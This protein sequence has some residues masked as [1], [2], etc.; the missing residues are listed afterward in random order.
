MPHRKVIAGLIGLPRVAV[1]ERRM[2]V[3][4]NVGVGFVL[5]DDQEHV[6]EPAEFSN[7][8]GR[9]GRSQWQRDQHAQAREQITSSR[10]SVL[11][12]YAV[13]PQPW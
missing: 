6:I 13:R 5:H 3:A 4:E 12:D 11:P 2:G 9:F 10:H 7:R 1:D 8:Q